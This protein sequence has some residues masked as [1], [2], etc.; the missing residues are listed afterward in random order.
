MKKQLL[1]YAAVCC[2]LLFSCKKDNL[3]TPVKT[4]STS[5]IALA[6]KGRA[7]K[8]TTD[9]TTTP[10]P[11]TLVGGLNV[12]DR[13]AKGDGVTDDTQAI[14][15]AIIYAKANGY[16]SVYFPTGTY[17]IQQLG[18]TTGIIPLLNGVGLQGDGATLTHIKLSA[19]RYNP[20]SIFYQAWWNEPA[21]SNV[22]IQGIDFDG[23][24]ANQKYDASYEYC[25][26][27]SI[28]NGQ[29]IEVKN[30]KF[31]SFRGDGVLFGDTFLSSPN[32]RGTSNVN[33]H[34]NEFVNIYREGA[35]F[36]ATK[37]GSFYN[38]YVHGDGYAV[39]G[40]DIERHSVN[41]TVINI[42]VYNNKF[43]FRDGYGPVERGGAIVRYRRAVTMGFFY[44][45]Y[46]N[47]TADGLASGH[48]IYGNQI[49][50]GQIDCWGHT[51]V[52]ITGNTFVNTYENTDG[53]G[54][55]TPAAIQISDPSSTQ[56]LVGIT[57]SNNNINSAMGGN[58]ILFN[59]YNG[60][61]AKANTIT[62]TKG[63]A[64]NIYR[65]GG[66][67][68]GNIIQ[69]I[70]SSTYRVS[71]FVINETCS[72]LVIANNQVT[73]TKTGTNRGI[74][75]AIAMQSFNSAA[76]APAIQNN[77]ATNLIQGV[78]SEFYTQ[79]GYATLIGNIIK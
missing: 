33:V 36:C 44:A 70:G 74:N 5:D 11:V 39:G 49:Y 22:V 79:A 77:I 57:V 78:V 64:I 19:G 9:T 31:Q 72:G 40:V 13:G 48:S 35:M 38:N 2:T 56:G 53:V 14:T 59:N 7:P 69:N 29:N 24:L 60:I 27:L 8:A 46:T 61:I 12:K 65:S 68:D 43:D 63:D 71:G 45:G 3:D 26:A 4:D 25:H 42:A 66:T 32:L 37:G 52:S 1:A 76:I 41:E 15:N 73:D 47:A 6:A 34:D 55:L 75:Y 18:I 62:A 51:N 54:W 20:T 58:G 16:K 10:A 67:F 50:Q 17:S 23:N 21:V 30:C 28:N